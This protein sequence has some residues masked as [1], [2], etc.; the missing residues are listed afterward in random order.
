MS[1]DGEGIGVS[2]A[3][4]L[5]RGKKIILK[6]ETTDLLKPDGSFR[7]VT[8]LKAKKRA[9]YPIKLFA[10]D[11][12]IGED[13]RPNFGLVDSTFVK[14]PRNMGGKSKYKDDKKNKKSK[15]KK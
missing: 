4:L 12:A 9:I 2:Y 14:V 6:D 1:R 5:I 7:I 8:R 10:A 3:Y 13:G 15:K 11:T